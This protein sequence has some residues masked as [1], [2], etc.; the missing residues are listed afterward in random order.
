M[1]AQDVERIA[2]TV[3]RELGA[4]EVT[5]VVSPL[6]AADRW[7][8]TVGG[9]RPRSLRIRAGEGTTAQFVREQIFEQLERR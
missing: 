7:E 2:R 9:P 3:L 5:L 8:I 4:G 6:N 1:T